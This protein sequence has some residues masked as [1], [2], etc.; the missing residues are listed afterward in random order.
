M[1]KKLIS[2]ALALVM[3][4]AIQT[5][6]YIPEEENRRQADPASPEAEKAPEDQTEVSAKPH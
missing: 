4:A 5:G 6:G 2:L 1:S 3:L